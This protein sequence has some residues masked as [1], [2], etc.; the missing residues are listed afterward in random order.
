MT[1]LLTDRTR[2]RGAALERRG[3]GDFV[4]HGDRWTGAVM[5]LEAVQADAVVWAMEVNDD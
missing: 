2:E 5:A 3:R 1:G 4:V